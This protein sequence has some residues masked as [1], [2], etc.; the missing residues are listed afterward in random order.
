MHHIKS[1]LNTCLRWYCDKIRTGLMGVKVFG[2]HYCSKYTLQQKLIEQ[3]VC[4]HKILGVIIHYWLCHKG[5]REEW[6]GKK[7]H[8]RW[9]CQCSPQSA[10]TRQDTRI[11]A[12]SAYY[13]SKYAHFYWLTAQYRTTTAKPHPFMCSSARALLRLSMHRQRLQCG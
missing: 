2:R 4:F 7:E 8:V 11:K 6:G 9:S 10:D 12:D 1:Q 5:F 3:A 13:W